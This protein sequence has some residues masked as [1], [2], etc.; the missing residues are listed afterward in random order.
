M[1]HIL[2]SLLPLLII[3][4]LFSCK[5]SNPEP[6]EKKTFRTVLLYLAANN[7]LSNE[8]YDNLD[9]IEN[10][11]AEVDG[12]MI[13]YARLPNSKP[14]LYQ[15]QNIKGKKEKR[16]IKEFEHQNSSDPTVL[17]QIINE[18][19]TSYESESYGL[20][21]WSH[22]TGWVPANI[23]PIK[24]KSFGNDNGNEMDIKNL[25]SAIPSNV[26][27]F[28]MF[29]ACSMASVEVLYEIKDKTE[30]FI[31]SPGEV[32]SNGMPYEKMVNDLFEKGTQAYINIA[33]KYYN[34]YNSLSGNFQ[35]ATISVVD[36]SKLQNI[37][38]LTKATMQSQHPLFNDFKRNE[39]QRMDFDRFSNP[40]I[41]FDFLDF[42]E[43][44]YNTPTIN[45]L[46]DAINEAVIYKANTA[47]FNG[48]IINKHSGLT[49]YIPI[50]DNENLVHDY[51][52]T[53]KWH[54]ASGFN[55]IL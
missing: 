24:L 32:I 13:V 35:S 4:F 29:D 48:H 30:H 14:A 51:Y 54:S 19:I 1:K 12:N 47:K 40:L 18:V 22:A 9:Q 42:M 44:N 16:K 7:N 38:N 25:N 17:R 21:L 8:A 20:I 43:T 10:N 34:H 6:E 45:T 49:C 37:A 11:I 5:D 52:R 36:A 53:L 50:S 39:I 31:V 23:G 15:I 26:F 41:A 33:N 28:I 2:N 46:K 55:T 27:D 3:S